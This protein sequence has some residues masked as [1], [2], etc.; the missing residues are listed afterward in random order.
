MHTS[1][2]VTPT[3][4]E[5]PNTHQHQHPHH[6]YQNHNYHYNSPQY[7]SSSS[8]S[9]SSI[10]NNNPNYIPHDQSTTNFTNSNPTHHLYTSATTNPTHINSGTPST[11]PQHKFAPARRL[12]ARQTLRLQ[13]PK[14]QGDTYGFQNACNAGVNAASSNYYKYS[15]SQLPPAPILK[16]NTTTPTTAYHTKNS[17]PKSASPLE[18]HKLPNVVCSSA[19]PSPQLSSTSALHYNGSNGGLSIQTATATPT[20]SANKFLNLRKPSITLNSA[21]VRNNN[22]TS[23]SS[24]GSCG[25]D[26]FGFAKELSPSMDM[27]DHSPIFASSISPSTSSGCS[28]TH[29]INRLFSLSPSTMRSYGNVS[30]HFITFLLL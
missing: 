29:H 11:S 24:I 19:S 30:M 18:S 6:G 27:S 26:L 2:L 5:T 1:H 21:D 22:G 28:P 25:S 9:S 10:N 15:P 13:I 20:S 8:S 23:G 7:H 17:L 14:Q 12:A 4:A 3:A 16:R